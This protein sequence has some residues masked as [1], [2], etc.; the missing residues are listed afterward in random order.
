MKNL[1][2]NQFVRFLGVGGVATS[3][4]YAVL[5]FL[6]EIIGFYAVLSSFLGAFAGAVI[7]YILNYHITFQA[8]RPHRSAMPRFFFIAFLSLA[9]NTAL[10]TFFVEQAG[11]AYFPSQILTT[12]LLI[13]ITF[14][15]NRIWTFHDL[16]VKPEE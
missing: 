13:I 5:L 11:F 3:L 4:H 8:T 1:F 7:S 16:T 2:K 14:G 6:V 12:F 9:L 10:M 15:A